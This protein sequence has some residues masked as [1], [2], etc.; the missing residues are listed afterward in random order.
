MWALSDEEDDNNA[1]VQASQAQ[2]SPTAGAAN[3]SSA[4][5]Q[6]QQMVRV[7]SERSSCHHGTCFG[8]GLSSIEAGRIFQAG[9]VADI[10]IECM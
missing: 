4:T 6:S 8:F 7:T 9:Q 10:L 1:V 3:P 2:V 5:K